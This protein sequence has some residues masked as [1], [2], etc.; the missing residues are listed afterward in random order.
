MWWHE[1]NSPSL[2]NPAVQ[3][4]RNDEQITRQVHPVGSDVEPTTDETGT[5]EL[6]ENKSPAKPG[7]RGRV[8]RGGSR[9]ANHPQPSDIDRWLATIDALE[10]MVVE[11]HLELQDLR[12]AERLQND[13]HAEQL[14]LAKQALSAVEDDRLA[15]QAKLVAQS[16]QYEVAAARH[17]QELDQLRG[18]NRRLCGQVEREQQKTSV[19]DKQLTSLEARFKTTQ[20]KHDHELL[21]A[22]RA[23]QAA[24]KRVEELRLASEQEADRLRQALNAESELAAAA[25]AKTEALRKQLDE[26]DSQ[27][28]LANERSE[29]LEDELSQLKRQHCSQVENLTSEHQAGIAELNQQLK[30]QRSKLQAAEGE[31]TRLEITIAHRDSQ[32]ACQLAKAEQA[33][34]AAQGTA[35][36]YEA[37]VEHL[38]EVLLRTSSAESQRAFLFST[39]MA[40]LQQELAAKDA[41]IEKEIQAGRLL[42]AK[43]LQF[44]SDC[45]AEIQQLNAKLSSSEAG[46]QKRLLD[47]LTLEEIF[48]QREQ[49]HCV[50]LADIKK[51]Y[52]RTAVREQQEASRRHQAESEGL[53]RTLAMANQEKSQLAAQLGGVRQ[54]LNELTA[55]LAEARRSLEQADTDLAERDKLHADKLQSVLA[56]A[57]QQ[58]RKLAAE[59]ALRIELEIVLEQTKNHAS[60]Q[61]ALARR[62]EASTCSQL[63]LLEVEY[64]SELEKLEAEIVSLE[65]KLGDRDTS[66]AALTAEVTELEQQVSELKKLKAEVVS[67]ECKLGDSRHKLGSLNGRGDRA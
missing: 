30:Q 31:L 1:A 29:K 20:Q 39:R 26:L 8:A 14:A 58:A 53:H 19:L 9:K 49:V 55:R 4:A 7:R 35:M 56:A 62:A 50:Q 22:N 63:K 34:L 59:Q 3:A 15:L 6:A 18:E 60:Q 48:N 57:D 12:S 65:C 13:S 37:R 36:L 2:T 45:V 44:K 43:L 42:E 5:G 23:E 46:A 54:Q 11:Q 17:Q 40:S 25:N 52:E 51:L 21:H 16:K 38:S 41:S 10:D 64:A 28:L 24:L 32:H 27:R 33:E 66:L 61:I 47:V 67:L